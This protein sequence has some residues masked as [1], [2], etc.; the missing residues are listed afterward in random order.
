MR[1][2]IVGVSGASGVQ[3]C[4]RLLL[5]L[6]EIKDLEV[7]LVISDGAKEVIACETEYK[8]EDFEKLAYRSYD[9]KN[10]AAL[11]SSGSFITDGMIILPCSM[12]TL[13]ALANAYCDDLVVRAADVCIKECR[14]VVIVPRETPLNI[15]HLKNLLSAAEAGY[16]VLPPVLT[17]YSKYDTVEAQTDH[18][19]GKI[20]MQFDI[21]YSKMKPWKG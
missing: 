2:I 16:V 11:I 18:I 21:E 1:R 15:I 5:A 8:L 6:K 13:S 10:M 3:L 4:Y 14:K 17:M 20:L 9:N 19:I 7:H 12:K